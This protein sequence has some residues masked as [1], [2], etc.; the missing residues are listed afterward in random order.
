MKL[1]LP[2]NINLLSYWIYAFSSKAYPT[3]LLETKTPFVP[4]GVLCMFLITNAG[5]IGYDP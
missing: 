2:G 5:E 1:I 4:L 3:I